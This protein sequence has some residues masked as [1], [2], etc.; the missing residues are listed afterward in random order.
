MAFTKRNGFL[1]NKWPPQVFYTQFSFGIRTIAPWGKLH[2]GAF[3]LEP[4]LSLP[5]NWVGIRNHELIF[6]YTQ[7]QTFASVLQNKCSKFTEK[8]RCLSKKRLQQWFLPENCSKF[9]RTPFSQNTSRQ[10]VPVLSLLLTSAYFIH[11]SFMGVRNLLKLDNFWKKWIKIREWRHN[12]RHNRRHNISLTFR[13]SNI[14][15]KI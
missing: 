3:V 12:W 15:E 9:L 7:K 8:H 5:V 2:L 1:K 10:L 6:L 4:L 13:N 11:W 14:N